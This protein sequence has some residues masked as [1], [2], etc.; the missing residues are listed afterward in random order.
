MESATRTGRFWDQAS[1]PSAEF[2]QWGQVPL[3]KQEIAKRY[4]G[5]PFHNHA[6][7]DLHFMRTHCGAA[8]FQ[9][10]ISIGCGL[11]RKELWLLQSGAVKHFDLYDLSG[12]RVAA[13]AAKI[14]ERKLQGRAHVTMGDG[15]EL[16]RN[17]QYDLVF[18]NSSLHHMYPVG[19]AISWSR[20]VLVP[21]G[22]F[23]FREYTGGNRI[24]YSAVQLAIANAVR[25]LLPDRL[26]QHPVDSQKRIPRTVSSIPPEKIIAADPSEARDSESIL[27]EFVKCFP[28]GHVVHLGGVIWFVALRNLY[29]NFSDSPEDA[30]LLLQL[31]RL[32]AVLAELG[33]SLM[34][35]GCAKKVQ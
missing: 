23:F 5:E 10:A 19:D 27:P 32:D 31:L 8:S 29:Q 12:A 13:V 22:V 9:R 15:L 17:N 26:F 33:V 34:S 4:T 1:G 30:E 6:E 11:A 16:A 35:V 21:D 14:Q 24:Q 18:W 20:A 7:A 2:L 3:V 28:G 25:G